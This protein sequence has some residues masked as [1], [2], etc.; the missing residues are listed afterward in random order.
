MTNQVQTV[1]G[2][3]D[4]KQLKS[5]KGYIEEMVVCMS[6]VKATNQSMADIIEIGRAHV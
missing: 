5:L 6:R 4:E 2:T 1:Y 3:F